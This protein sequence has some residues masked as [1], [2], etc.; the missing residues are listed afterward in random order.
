MMSCCDVLSY[1]M[2]CYAMFTRMPCHVYKNAM[3]FKNVMFTK[4]PWFQ[5]C[6][7]F[8]NAMVSEMPCFQEGHVMA[9]VEYDMT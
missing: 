4:M 2:T 5:E 6:H 8:K 9:N 7:V 1:V 3:V